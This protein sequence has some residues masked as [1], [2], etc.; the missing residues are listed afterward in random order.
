MAATS[1]LYGKSM[2]AKTLII[3]QQVVIR[4]EFKAIKISIMNQAIQINI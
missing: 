1:L 3:D 2:P 4:S